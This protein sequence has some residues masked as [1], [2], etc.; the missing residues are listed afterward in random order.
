MRFGFRWRTGLPV[1]LPFCSLLRRPC[2]GLSRLFFGPD[3][4]YWRGR[5]APT[6]ARTFL[7]CVGRFG[8]LPWL[9]QLPARARQGGFFVTQAAL[10]RLCSGVRQ[11]AFGQPLLQ[12][13]DAALEWA[14]FVLG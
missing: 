10:L 12:D 9:R 2:C 14:L 13:A 1:L 5:W 6:R 3:R 11:S 8:V 7:P 4:A